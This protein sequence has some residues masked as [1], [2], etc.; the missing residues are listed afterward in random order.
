MALLSTLDHLVLVCDDLQQGIDYCERMLG[1]RPPPGGQH[2]R[3]A[4]HN[5]LLNLGGGVYL[6]V[7]AVDPHVPA[8]AHA[9]WFGMD[10]R[11]AGAGPRLTTFVARTND[12]VAAAQALPVLGPVCEMQRNTLSWQITIRPDGAL[13]DDGAVPALIQWPAG[14]DPTMTMPDLGCRFVALEI[15][16]PRP[17]QLRS[18]WTRIGLQTS[19]AM[20]IKS[21]PENEAPWLVAHIDTA[22]GRTILSGQAAG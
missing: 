1:V 18:A 4:T 6:E 7:I 5:H 15:F 19:G 2:L 21:C 9:R 14:V 16:H 11:R 17:D 10:E 3:M 12:I 22:H 13:N 20:A 8:P